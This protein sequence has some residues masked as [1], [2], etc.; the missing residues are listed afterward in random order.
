MEFK[1]L[2]KREIQSAYFFSFLNVFFASIVFPSHY[3]QLDTYI[4]WLEIQAVFV[5]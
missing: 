1:I 4:E 3:I 5:V 2:K